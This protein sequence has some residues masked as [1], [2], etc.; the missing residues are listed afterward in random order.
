MVSEGCLVRVFVPRFG[1]RATMRIGLVAFG[2]QCIVVGLATQPEHIWIAVFFSL[3]S[4]LVYPSLSSLVSWSVPPEQQGEAQ[5]AINGIRA[6]TE[7]LGPLCFSVLMNMF[8]DTV[9]PGAPYLCGSIITALALAVSFRIPDEDE[10]AAYLDAKVSGEQRVQ[11]AKWLLSGDEDEDEDE[12]NDEGNGGGGAV[13]RLVGKAEDQTKG[14]NKE[15]AGRFRE[16]GGAAKKEKS[17][18]PGHSPPRG[19]SK[20]ENQR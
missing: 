2:C 19:E 12:D 9:V 13:G 17:R 4:N 16:D 3:F 18:G 5:G 1:E 8:E 7:G 11:E 10:Y 6:L 20:G 14:W 15:G